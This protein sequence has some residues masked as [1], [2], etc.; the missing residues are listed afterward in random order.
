MA[1]GE[2]PTEESV[3]VLAARRL[4]PGR[5][6]N[7]ALDRLADFAARLLG[8][9][10]A[11][12]SL[13]TDVQHV[14]SGAGLAE[15]AI[16]STGPLGES[17]CT[18]TLRSGEPL[19]VEDATT[20][21]RVAGLAPVTSGTV[22]SYLGV[23]L[24]TEDGQAVGALCV[25]DPEPRSWSEEDVVLLEQ[26]A[27]PVA[28]ELTLAALTTEHEA[29]RV[30]WELAF[31]AAGIGA[32]DWDLR[33]G[34]LRWDDRLL[35]LFGH[36]S[37]TF[38]GTIEAF[39]DVVHPDDR[40]RVTAALESAIESCSEYT[41]EYRIV[42]PDGG[43]RWITAQGRALPGADGTAVRL[44]GAA[45][46][47][48]ALL[49]GEAHVQ[50][51]LE[52]MPSAFFHVDDDWRFTYVNAEGERLL[53]RSRDELVGGNL[54]ELF[55]DAAGGDFG[56]LYRRAVA[57]GEPVAFDA[58][59]PEPL[60]GWYEVRA[61]PGPDG[62]AVYFN[63]VTARREVEAQ[64]QRA[65]Q[66]NELLAAV[67]AELTQTLDV[68]QAVGRLA[69]LVVPA[70][71]DWC[72]VTLVG[73]DTH[74]DWRRRLTDVGGA[75]AEPGERPLLERYTTLRLPEL[76][77]DSL[78]ARALRTGRRVV[79]RTGAQAVADTALRPS[80]AQELL[81]RLDP[82]SFAVIP[83]PGRD[84]TV[85]LLTAA[86]TRSRPGFLDD[87]VDTLGEV[88]DRAGLAVDNARLFSQQRDLA[89]A[90]QRSLLT[91]PLESEHVEVEVRYVPATSAAQVG[92]DWY[93]SF[94]Q[95]DGATVLVIGDV[96]G[97][98]TA[99]AAAMG[100]VRSLLRGTAAHTGGGPAD[101]LR[102]VDRVMRTL[103]VDTTAT[104]VVARLEGTE[105]SAPTRLR[106]SN[107]GH[108]PPMVVTPDGAVQALG[109]PES[110]LLLGLDPTTARTEHVM[111][112]QSGAT[113]LLYTDG[114]VERRGQS[115]DLGLKLLRDTLTEVAG[116]DVDL[117]T[118]CDQTLHR[119]RPDRPDDDVALLAI[120]LRG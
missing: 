32:F 89:T 94:L 87:D 43:L 35:G 5:G 45:F 25:F 78:V 18:V 48:T 19:V 44:L 80:E 9:S 59:Y 67:A 38:G 22:G 90:L 33:T 23:P 4:V 73:D 100:Q 13:L 50:R 119:M 14:A 72:L 120:R 83:L 1:E 104:A 34:E 36:D 8:S 46:D 98:D 102:G 51:V 64:A 91:P 62:V 107:A 58:F 61:W 54:W 60:N 70:L 6:G 76:T 24:M 77:D 79:V 69:S 115:L 95:D 108:P 74:P 10:S 109:A 39:N 53:G 7:A 65:A 16:G 86:R 17:L 49:E 20:D 29:E 52:A 47:T 112:L 111:P 92:G 85:G 55:P 116:A 11:Q 113:V 56:A 105:P 114:L 99:A 101:I 82:A 3:R 66:R 41:A 118:L 93:D 40:A 110:D 117:A 63:D 106:W 71:A 103:Q 31:D 57:T 75:H 68:E 26:L 30:V 21:E 81:R 42:L 97:H 12:V 2:R 28:A 84:R 15:G 88:A 27:G 37:T 96:I